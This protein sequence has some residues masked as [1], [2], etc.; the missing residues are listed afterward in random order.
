M[1]PSFWQERWDRNQIGFHQAQVTPYLI[2]HW[3]S[4]GLASDSRVLVPLCG[5]SLD[6]RWLAEQGHRVLGI[7]LA[8]K[9]V[10][11]FFAEQGWLAQISEQGAFRVYRHGALELWCGDFFAL[12]AQDVADCMAWFDRAALIALPEPLRSRYWAHLQAVLP[13][14]CAG[15]LITLE[16][17]QEQMQGPPFSVPASEVRAHMG[18][19][20]MLLEVERADIL[21]GDWKF[22]RHQLTALDEVVWRVQR[23]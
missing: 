19:A 18:A 3:P 17:D 21:K 16:Y 20:G 14:C 10:A 5:K 12:T 7:E 11:A 2:R 23:P 6:L 9:A 15:L 22:I 8:E 4:L 1:Q 13:E